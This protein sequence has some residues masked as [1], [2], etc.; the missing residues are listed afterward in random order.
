MC[1]ETL[2]FPWLFAASGPLRGTARAWGLLVALVSC[3][4]CPAAD[5]S[6]REQVEADWL[7]QAQRWPASEQNIAK[8]VGDAAGA[9]DGV[10]NGKY[11]FHTGLEPNPWWQVDLGRRRAIVRILVFNRLDY[12]PTGWIFTRLKKASF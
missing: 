1:V 3:S 8:T 10:K 11:A 12:G 7:R 6:M 2:I 4:C 5:L 9:V